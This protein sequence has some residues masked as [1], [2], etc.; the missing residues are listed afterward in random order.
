[1]PKLK[2]NGKTKNYSYSPSGIESYKKAL[3]KLKKRKNNKSGDQYVDMNPPPTPPGG[4]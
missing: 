2:V 1:M 4:E 3:K